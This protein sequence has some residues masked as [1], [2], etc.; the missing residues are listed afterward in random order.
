MQ[1][2]LVQR[3][4]EREHDAD[5]EDAL[6]VVFESSAN[7]RQHDHAEEDDSSQV[8]ARE[9]GAQ[10]QRFVEDDAVPDE[11]HEQRPDHLQARHGEGEQKHRGQVIAVRAQPMEV[12]AEMCAACPWTTRCCGG[13]RAAPVLTLFIEA[14]VL[15][16]VDEFLVALPRRTSGAH[17]TTWTPLVVLVNAAGLYLPKSVTA[18]IN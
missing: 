17:K 12:F 3:A 5:V 8:E 6:P 2:A 11:P 18:A 1:Q 13:C 16:V 14:V 9:A 4:P 10:V 15:I 7:M